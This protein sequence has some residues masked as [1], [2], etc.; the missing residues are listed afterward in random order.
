MSGGPNECVAEIVALLTTA[1]KNQLILDLTAWAGW[2]VTSVNA[3][4]RLVDHVSTIYTAAN[5]KL[6][7]RE[8]RERERVGEKERERDS[9]SRQS[10]LIN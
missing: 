9:K 8:E 4:L 3:L 10:A 5:K 6:R 2:C 1:H 7:E